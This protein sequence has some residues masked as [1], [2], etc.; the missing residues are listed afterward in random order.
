MAAWCGTA[1]AA[2][3]RLA[4][5]VRLLDRELASAPAEVRHILAPA[6]EAVRRVAEL[7]ELNVRIQWIGRPFDDA[8]RRGRPQYVQRAIRKADRRHAGEHRAWC[9]PWRSTT[10]AAPS[11]SHAAREALGRRPR[12]VTQPTIAEHLYLPE[13]PPVDVLV[14]TRGEH[15][16]SN[17][18]LWQSVGAPSTSPTQPWPDFDA[19]E[20]DAAARRSPCT[21]KRSSTTAHA[22]TS[23]RHGVRR[24]RRRSPVAWPA[25]DRPGQQQMAEARRRGDR[26]RHAPRRA[27][28]D[29]H[30]QDDGLPRPAVLVGQEGRRRHRDEGA[31]GPAG[32]Q[33]PAVPRRATSGRPYRRG[34]CSRG[35]ATTSACS[36]LREIARRRRQRQLEL[37][38]AGAPRRSRSSG[39]PSGPAPPA[40]ATSAELDWTP[41][42]QAWRAVSVGSDEC[43]GA[44]RCP[45]GE[46][47][48]A[49]RARRAGRRR[50][51]RRRQHAPLR[52]GRRQRR[53]DPARARRRR[54]RRGPHA[55]G[56]R[57]RH[58]RRRDRPAPVHLP[59][60]R[61]DAGCSTTRT[62]PSA[63]PTIADRSARRCGR[64]SASGCRPDLDPAVADVLR[65]ARLGRRHRDWR[66]CASDHDRRRRRQADARC[67]RTTLPPGSADRH[68][69]SR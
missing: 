32:E 26:R 63:S 15:R 48:F 53:R 58:R 42:D 69:T 24:A 60:R 50:R 47:C 46:P 7:N 19:A 6:P 37:E 29:R 5:R 56:H 10:A 62:R 16:M 27:G 22:T 17:F 2:R 49:E 44:D 1:V 66:S 41:S 65:H 30:G 39:S 11:W 64:S 67:G 4:H 54:L 25:E 59:R 23:P 18:M 36:A 3:H 14:R 31:A 9:S 51:R 40:P 52:A 33:G 8:A 61:R 12:P 38:H 20:L 34:R 13:L 55:R 45:I 68:S 43:P 21:V 28:R 35:A 57:Q